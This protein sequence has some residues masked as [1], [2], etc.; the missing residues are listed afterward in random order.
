MNNWMLSLLVL[1]GLFAV[2]LAGPALAD[3]A[4]DTA[5]IRARIEALRARVE[6]MEQDQT[7]TVHREE[8]TRMMRDILDDAKAQPAMP[9]WMKNLTFYGDLRL[10]YQY[11]NDSGRPAGYPRGPDPSDQ[12]FHERKDRN[13]VRFR[14]RF[15]M[16]K[17]WWDKQM[18]VGFRLA[19]DGTGGS[20]PYQANSANQTFGGGFNKK[21]IGIDLAYAKYMPNC[22]EGLTIMGGKV[23][24]PIRTK[25]LVT[26]D[27]DINPEGFAI[28]YQMPFFG[29]FKPYV[30]AGFWL[31]GEDETY[32]G[33]GPDEDDDTRRDPVVWTVSAGFDWKIAEDMKL[34]VGA[35]WYKWK[36]YRHVPANGVAGSL[37]QGQ[38]PGVYERGAPGMENI[39]LTSKFKWKMLD[40]P[41]Q[42]W[43]TWVHNCADYYNENSVGDDVFAIGYGFYD[44]HFKDKNDAFA[45]GIKVGKNKK[46]G[47]WSA[48]VVYYYVQANA[49]S[50]ATTDSDYGGPNAKG[51]KMG[52]K[53]NIDDFLTVGATA[54]IFDPV[55]GDSWGDTDNASFVG[56]NR[57][58]HFRLQVDLAW[59]F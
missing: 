30:Q 56:Y 43:G 50:P 18:E 46:K 58:T 35:T 16:K 20:D 1:T 29:D 25:T 23:K 19:S 4:S 33:Y 14:V 59:K 5:S 47:D 28:D 51:W 40:L 34:F 12:Q 3:E 22:V 36:H 39:E 32:T 9:S 26:W 54:F 38:L 2:S 24:N 44:R 57:D 48:K 17:T 10:R 8:V 55:D 53:Y 27:G 49:V 42:V 45:L 11:D 37:E 41:W 52:G 7:K 31:L 13:R 6:Q 21:R 15:G